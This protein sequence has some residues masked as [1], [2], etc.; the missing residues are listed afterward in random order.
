MRDLTPDS[1]LTQGTGCALNTTAGSANCSDIG[2][3]HE[4]F[5]K[6]L[7]TSAEGA[8]AQCSGGADGTT[9][10]TD[11]SSST[12]DGSQGLGQSLSA[13]EIIL[14]NLPAVQIRNV[15][16]TGTV[17]TGSGSNGT[18]TGSNNNNSSSGTSGTPSSSTSAPA[19]TN[20]AD[21]YAAS[22]LALLAGVGFAVAFL[23]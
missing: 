8:A 4:N 19:S 11:W 15:N 5:N 17:I 22:T 7:Q 16:T 20:A 2:T 9:C 21:G 6:L 18:A 10:G 13:L 12:W 23:V 14:A 1:R 3:L